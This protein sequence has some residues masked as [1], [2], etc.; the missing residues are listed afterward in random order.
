M[1]EF[2]IHYPIRLHQ[3]FMWKYFTHVKIFRG[4]G[5]NDPV[6]PGMLAL[7]RK[8]HVEQFTSLPQPTNVSH[9]LG[10]MI[11]PFH[12]CCALYFNKVAIIQFWH[13]SKAQTKKISQNWPFEEV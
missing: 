9:Q 1:Y 3:Y 5:E 10:G 13:W 12:N 6:S 2:F 7:G 4:R 11:R 8:D